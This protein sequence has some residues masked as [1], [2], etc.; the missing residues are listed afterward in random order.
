MGPGLLSEKVIGQLLPKRA[1]MSPVP[2][3]G[4]WLSGTMSFAY[5][6]AHWIA[7]PQNSLND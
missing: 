2:R 3:H 7:L 1:S 6:L 5:L 4:A